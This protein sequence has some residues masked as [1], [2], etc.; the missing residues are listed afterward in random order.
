M[1]TIKEKSSS[2]SYYITRRN[3]SVMTKNEEKKFEIELQKLDESRRKKNKRKFLDHPGNISQISKNTFGPVSQKNKKLIS[4]LSSEFLK[5]SSQK[6]PQIVISRS[7]SRSKSNNKM[8]GLPIRS[9]TPNNYIPLK[10]SKY[11]SIKLDYSIPMGSRR[12]SIV[13]TSKQNDITK[14]MNENFYNKRNSYNFV[15]PEI[16]LEDSVNGKGISIYKKSSSVRKNESDDKSSFRSQQKQKLSEEKSTTKKSSPIK[17]RKILDIG[18]NYSTHQRFKDGR[19]IGQRFYDDFVRRK[20]RK[21]NNLDHKFFFVRKKKCG[22]L[23]DHFYNAFLQDYHN[24]QDENFL[25]I[26]EEKKKK[27]KRSRDLKLDMRNKFVVQK[28]QRAL[29]NNC[30]LKKKIPFSENKKIIEKRKWNIFPFKKHPKTKFSKKKKL[31]KT[32]FLK[33]LSS[34]FERKKKLKNLSLEINNR[35]KRSVTSKLSLSKIPKKSKLKKFS[36]KLEDKKSKNNRYKSLYEMLTT[37]IRFHN[38]G[39]LNQEIKLFDSRLSDFLNH[40]EVNEEKR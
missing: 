20:E 36:K 2:R 26:D 31:N 18:A 16:N 4:L 22:G 33:N 10:K 27:L 17:K 7:G 11:R 39:G 19:R 34:N 25:D 14:F 28:N 15:S 24:F 12:N 13:K 21:K 8:D 1:K 3:L 38:H 37:Q 35:R 40:N 32:F 30:G 23:K 6:T 5:D 29:F 9:K